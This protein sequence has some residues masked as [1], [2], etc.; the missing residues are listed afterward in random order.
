MV[1]Q[2]EGLSFFFAIGNDWV[3]YITLILSS[4]FWYDIVNIVFHFVLAL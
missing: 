4:I 1:V 2:H 3:C